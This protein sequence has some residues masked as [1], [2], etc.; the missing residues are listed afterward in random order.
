MLVSEKITG[1]SAYSSRGCSRPR[2]GSYTRSESSFTPL[3]SRKS[4]SL[5]RDKTKSSEFMCC[6][7]VDLVTKKHKCFPGICEAAGGKTATP[8]F[9]VFAIAHVLS[10]S[11]K[12]LSVSI[13]LLDY[14]LGK[15]NNDTTTLANFGSLGLSSVSAS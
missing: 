6:F 3:S 1:I 2:F 4:F 11:I 8:P 9:L 14:S 5:V 12:L 10:V 13:M 15:L 7:S